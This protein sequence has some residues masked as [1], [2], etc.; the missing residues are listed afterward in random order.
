LVVLAA[1]GI[2]TLLAALN[3]NYRDFRYVIPFT[4]QLWM[5]ATPSIYMDVFDASLAERGAWFQALVEL[6]PMTALVAAFRAAV[7]G[8][9]MPWLSLGVAAVLSVAAFVLGCLYYRR[10]ED[11]F[12]DVI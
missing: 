2:G 10:M 1:T 7:L 9:P 12:A 6:N 8:T 4:I 3:V 5:F 11:G